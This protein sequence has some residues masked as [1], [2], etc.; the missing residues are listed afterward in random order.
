M[1]TGRINAR[2][3]GRHSF[4]PVFYEYTR[5]S[6]PVRSPTRVNNVVRPSDA[7]LPSRFTKGLTLERNLTNVRTVGKPS[8]RG[9]PFECT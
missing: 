1:E 7:L 2:N 4:V 9:Q 3:A 6:T 8:A 5:E